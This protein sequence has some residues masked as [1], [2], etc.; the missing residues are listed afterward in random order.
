MWNKG[1]VAVDNSGVRGHRCAW[2][3]AAAQLTGVTACGQAS[4]LVETA[5]ASRRACRQRGEGS[6]VG[7]VLVPGLEDDH[8]HAGATAGAGHRTRGT[9]V[10]D[11]VRQWR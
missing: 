10:D 8:D 2:R 3:N 1:A 5:L 6:R 7:T 11:G 4:R 9:P